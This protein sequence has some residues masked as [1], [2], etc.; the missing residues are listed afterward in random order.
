[1][2]QIANNSLLF[3]M[4]DGEAKK[5]V[6]WGYPHDLCQMNLQILMKQ[7]NCYISIGWLVSRLRIT[8]E[9]LCALSGWKVPNGTKRL[10]IFPSHSWQSPSSSWVGFVGAA[11]ARKK[12]KQKGNTYRNRCILRKSPLAMSQSNE[13]MPMEAVNSPGYLSLLPLRLGMIRQVL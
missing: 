13:L 6:A 1:M 8:P 12:K 9:L 7:F 4:N 3:W 5:S 10:I 11:A 2:N